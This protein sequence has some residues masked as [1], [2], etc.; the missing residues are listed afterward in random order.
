MSTVA[1]D[2][3]NPAYDMLT[4]TAAYGA[5]AGTIATQYAASSANA[6]WVLCT[7]AA[8]VF[9]GQLGTSATTA[10]GVPV[11]ANVP[12]IVNVPTNAEQWIVSAIRVGS[13]GNLYCKPLQN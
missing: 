12:V 5:A 9:V 13:D 2:I 6:V 8:Y 4:Q 1:S 3:I 7:T 11:A 10:N